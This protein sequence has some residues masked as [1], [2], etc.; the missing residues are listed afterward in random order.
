MR[1]TLLPLAFLLAAAIAVPA[2]ALAEEAPA[3]ADKADK[4]EK[5]D[6]ADKKKGGEHKIT[7]SESFLGLDPL[8]TSI[9][10]G[11]RPLGLL[12][13]GIGL[14]VP[15][16]DLR[17]RV[18][19]DMPQLRDAYV[20]ALMSF[21]ATHVRSWR[22]PDVVALADRLQGVTDRVLAKKGARVLLGQV[23]IQLN[24]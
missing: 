1:R 4:P 2:P 17:E 3:K 7:Q 23:A 15:D 11:N 9:M 21:T 8:Y 14:D 18:D 22:Q 12:M 20:R 6:K 16:K 5:A 19:H 10:D 24:N 13:V